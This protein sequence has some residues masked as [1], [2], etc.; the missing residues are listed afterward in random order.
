[1]TISSV[2]PNASGLDAEPLRLARAGLALHPINPK[3]KRP[4]T[5]H[6]F[7]DATTD[8]DQIA[9]W[10]GQH[11]ACDWATPTSS[12]CVLD[13][14]A[15]LSASIPVLEAALGR[16]FTWLIDQCSL[17]AWTPRGGLHLLWRRTPWVAVRTGAG[18]IGKAI[19][20]RGHRA[21]GT[22]TG[23]WILPNG[24]DRIIER[25]SPDDVIHERLARPPKGLLY[26]KHFSPR[27]RHE[28]RGNPEQRAAIGAADPTAWR[29]TYDAWTARQRATMA[30]RLKSRADDASGMRAQA[31][32]ELA[33]LT[34]GRPPA[35]FRMACR[36]ARYI[37]GNVL[38]AEEVTSA[39]IDAT[40]ANGLAA[41]RGLHHCRATIANG[42]RLGARDPLPPLM[43][44]F[45][46]N[47]EARP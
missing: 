2:G 15:P 28:I 36:I 9:L 39:L 5:E 27:E 42:L 18:C 17:V 45:R 26:L 22:P 21:D 6:G 44:R 14:D 23:Y 35:L 31:A 29:D 25:G 37:S 4:L 30:D 43:R 3:T 46:T 32:V 16:P 20:T 38:T 8:L 1:M 19:D 47:G 10:Q 11:P 40:V 12:F 13:I 34:E 7:H 33:A 41:K 24:R